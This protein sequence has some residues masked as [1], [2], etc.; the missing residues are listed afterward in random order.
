MFSNWLSGAL[1]NSQLAITLWWPV[2]SV[3]PLK[4][5]FFRE[6]AC[7]LS[8]R[9]D[10]DKTFSVAYFQSS[11]EDFR[12]CSNFHYLPANRGNS[13]VECF[14]AVSISST[15]SLLWESCCWFCS[16]FPRGIG[17]QR[18]EMSLVTCCPDPPG[19]APIRISNLSF[20]VL[21][22]ALW[23]WVVNISESGLFLSC[24]LFF[25]KIHT[26][27]HQERQTVNIIL[28]SVI[29]ALDYVVEKHCTKTQITIGC[30]WGSMKEWHASKLWVQ[31]TVL[32]Y[33]RDPF[34]KWK[35]MGLTET[36]S[37]SKLPEKIYYS[38][39]STDFRRNL[40]AFILQ[41][42]DSEWKRSLLAE[43]D[44]CI[45]TRCER[46]AIATS[47]QSMFLWRIWA[48]A[49]FFWIRETVPDSWMFTIVGEWLMYR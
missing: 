6:F 1:T 20:T 25:A 44:W 42:G 19:R 7:K 46:L 8:V 45:P 28:H 10:G 36:K 35:G 34:A 48:F 33:V 13:V 14:P 17:A 15:H 3:S 4:V 38:V 30:M 12:T 18:L 21:V 16:H 32:D 24:I 37:V 41:Q 39:R 49:H 26:C 11:N 27:L 47:Q 43:C 9:L 29:W 2:S 5:P 31:F 23:Q 40:V 22:I